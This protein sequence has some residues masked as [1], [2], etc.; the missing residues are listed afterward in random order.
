[1]W[2]QNETIKNLLLYDEKNH[3]AECEMMN[4]KCHWC[5]LSTYQKT[6]YLW[7]FITCIIMYWEFNYNNISKKDTNI[8]KEAL[9]VFL[10]KSKRMI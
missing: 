9:F 2:Q 3:T 5:L 4:Y 8:V 6:Q 10:N 1:M 7:K